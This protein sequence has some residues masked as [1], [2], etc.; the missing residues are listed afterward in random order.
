MIQDEQVT[1][2]LMIGA[3]SMSNGRTFLIY[4]AVALGAGLCLILL[5]L[6]TACIGKLPVSCEAAFAMFIGAGAIFSNGIFAWFAWVRVSEIV[7][8]EADPM[9]QSEALQLMRLVAFLATGSVA[10]PIGVY[11]LAV[12][13]ILTRWAALV[14][15]RHVSTAR[16]CVC[17]TLLMILSICNPDMLQIPAWRQRDLMG[18]P[19][20]STVGLCAL[21]ALIGDGLQLGVQVYFTFVLHTQEFFLGGDGAR[22]DDQRRYYQLLF[23]STV[24]ISLICSGFALASIWLRGLRRLSFYCCSR[25]A[26]QPQA[27]EP[28]W[29]EPH[30]RQFSSAGTRMVYVDGGR[31]GSKE[32]VPAALQRIRSLPPDASAEAR[33]ANLD[34]WRHASAQRPEPRDA[35]M[36]WL[37]ELEAAT[38][39]PMRV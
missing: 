28:V 3:N 17:T 27:S 8:L 34:A 2:N 33:M 11:A 13:L 7:S 20:A 37:Y 38:P 30:A 16:S 35:A 10:A 6:F 29:A 14:D 18:F 24:G 26:T 31:Q 15:E 39:E 36:R 32:P 21:G 12:C 5:V 9:M 23:S 4:H 19:T 1:G 25:K 22:Q